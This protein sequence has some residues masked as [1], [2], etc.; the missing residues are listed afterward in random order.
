MH[1]LAGELVGFFMFDHDVFL[2][3]FSDWFQILIKILRLTLCDYNRI[4][5]LHFFGLSSYYLKLTQA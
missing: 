1:L 2:G 4:I 3:E 5:P